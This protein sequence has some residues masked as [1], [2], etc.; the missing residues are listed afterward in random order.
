MQT[1]GPANTG[2]PPPDRTGSN[3]GAGDAHPADR[4]LRHLRRMPHRP[5]WWPADEEWPP[6]SRRPWPHPRRH[7]PF[8]RRLGC[9]FLISNLLGVVLLLGLLGFVLRAAGVSFPGL[10]QFAP[11]LPGG[12]LL[13]AV[14]VLLVLVSTMNLRRVSEPL[15]ELLEASERIAAGDYSVRVTGNG[16][17]EMRSMGIAFN[18]MAS[19][20]QTQDEQRRQW[21]ADVSHELRTPLTI[22]QGNLEGLIDDVYVAD[23]Q[24]LGSLLEEVRVL[25]RLADDLRV[26]A[27]AQDGNLKLRLEATDLAKLIREIAAAAQTQADTNGARLELAVEAGLPALEIDAER[28]KQVLNNLLS[29]A[30]RYTPSGKAVSVSLSKR[31]AHGGSWLA[32]SVRDQGPGIAPEDLPHVFDRYYKGADSRGM[33]LGLAIAKHIV[34]AHGGEISVSSSPSGGTTVSFSLPA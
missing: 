33:G 4:W 3:S 12:E 24:R 16:P 32:V 11:V 13:I 26:L 5:P 1:S 29:N 27:L 21:L 9:L 18:A 7:N 34:D 31:A 8:F 19:R 2:S 25:S 10:D 23:K 17:R 15:D 30:L 20:L 28:I 14:G 22:L 6:R